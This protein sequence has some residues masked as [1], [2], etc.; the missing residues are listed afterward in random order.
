[1]RTELF[2]PPVV[3]LGDCYPCTRIMRSGFQMLSA[4]GGD[5]EGCLD[6]PADSS[7][8]LFVLRMAKKNSISAQWRS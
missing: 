1:M 8:C 5:N 2:P 4:V 7:Y 3:E 6:A